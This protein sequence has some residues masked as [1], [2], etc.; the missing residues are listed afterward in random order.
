[1]M[2]DT[3]R[4]YVIVGA[5]LAGFLAAE[6]IR[7]EAPDHPLLMMTADAGDYYRKPMLS[8]AFDQDKTADDLLLF[9]RAEMMDRLSMEIVPHQRV[10][11]MDLAKRALTL[12]D[13]Q[14][15]AY[16]RLILALGSAPRTPDWF[17]SE[18]K[19]CVQVNHWMDY[20]AFRQQLAACDAKRVAVVGGG[21]VGI[22]FAHDLSG[23][24]R[25][26][27][28]WIHRG[29][30]P[31]DRHIPYWLGKPWLDALEKDVDWTSH[32]ETVV[33]DCTVNSDGVVLRLDSGKTIQADM[34]LAALGLAPS[35]DL[36][37]A[38][39][40]VLG[41]NGIVTDAYGQTSDPYVYALGDCAEMQGHNPFFV[42]PIRM[43][44]SALAKTLQGEPTQ[45]DFALPFVVRAKTSRCP[46]ALTWMDA[47]EG[48]WDIAGEAPHM[49]A[50][51]YS[52]SGHLSGFALMGDEAKNAAA[53]LSKLK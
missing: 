40:L 21:F 38:A 2:A 42:P 28:D 3:A 13:G 44:A 16:D 9:T 47:P 30:Y 33:Q 1:M 27:V 11:S 37:R 26:A 14:T 6:A 45:S 39:G 49:T 24:G 12:S 51:F 53:W 34:V 8:F 22:E 25:Y 20:Q 46:M 23:S 48:R 52:E 5:G 31:L 36:A 7:A 17:V 50:S 19:R 43:M 18:N 29:V 32:T 10:E 4:P 15:I 41:P 35:V